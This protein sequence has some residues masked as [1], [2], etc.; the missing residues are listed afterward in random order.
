MGAVPQPLP[1]RLSAEAILINIQHYRIFN[2]EGQ[3]RDTVLNA[4]INVTFYL[5]VSHFL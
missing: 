5:K 1:A 2:L 3:N 4:R